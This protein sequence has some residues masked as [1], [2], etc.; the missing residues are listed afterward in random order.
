VEDMEGLKILIAGGTG[1]IG[2]NLVHFFYKK[3]HNV[4]T[5]MR[6]QSNPWRI[7]NLL[8][9]ID[10]FKLDI[11]D[12]ERVNEVFVFFKP[13][14]VINTIAYGGYHFETDSARILGI[15]FNGTANLVESYVNSNAELLINTGS[16]SEYGFKNH[17]MS[18]QNILEPIG[19]YAVSKAAA[20]L[21]S[22]SRSIESNRKIVTLRLFSAYGEF[23]EAHRLIPYLMYS[24]IT[25][26]A[27]RL[28]DQNNMRDFIYVRD[29]CDAYGS[30]IERME[31]A[32][33]GEILNLGSGKEYKVAEVVSLIEKISG[34]KLNVE[35]Q[36]SEERVGDK[37]IR[38]LAETSK[39]NDILNW[40]PK[41]S[42]EKG[43]STTYSWFRENLEKYEVTENSKLKKLSE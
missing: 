29:I 17:P 41:Y 18:E 39:M 38:W 40:R 20:T 16:S 28:N 15:N 6:A 19:P 30:L 34:Q 12:K 9:D 8:T 4:A 2:S 37:A 27:A 10:I 25:A 42:L 23:E 13:D 7:S 3:G 31:K 11:T 32:S 36:H 22:R 35:W 26:K 5:T 1:F 33:L 14:I 24:S 21:Y 43:L